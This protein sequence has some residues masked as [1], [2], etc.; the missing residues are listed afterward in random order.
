MQKLLLHPFYTNFGS[1]ALQGKD[2]EMKNG[3]G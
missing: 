2:Y 1:S 3:K